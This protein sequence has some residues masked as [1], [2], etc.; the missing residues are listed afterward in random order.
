MATTCLWFLRPLVGA[1]TFSAPAV[2]AA[3]GVSDPDYL[4]RANYGD[5]SYTWFNIIG[6]T[7][8]ARW[9]G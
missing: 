4:Y 5:H 3:G 6:N 2:F 1:L 9:A 8:L 7:Y